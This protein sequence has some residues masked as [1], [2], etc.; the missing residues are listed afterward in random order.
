MRLKGLSVLLTDNDTVKLLCSFVLFVSKLK[1]KTKIIFVGVNE[2][3]TTFLYI[4]NRGDKKR[5][6]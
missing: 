1:L 6:E 3:L 2:K 5:E 4:L